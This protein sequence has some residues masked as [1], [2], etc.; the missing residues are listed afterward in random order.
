[1]SYYCDEKNVCKDCGKELPFET[2]KDVESHDGGL[3]PY[4]YKKVDRLAAKK[5]SLWFYCNDCYEKLETVKVG[6][7]IGAGYAYIDVKLK[8]ALTELKSD[9]DKK[10]EQIAELEKYILSTIDKISDKIYL[11][12]LTLDELELL[13]ASPYIYKPTYQQILVGYPS[14][15][16]F[17][18]IGELIKAIK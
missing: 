14:F 6:D 8:D 7:A 2:V 9:Y 15:E 4:E 10:V 1:M 12:E 5:V 16:G 11:N 3:Y 18:A 13:D 17:L